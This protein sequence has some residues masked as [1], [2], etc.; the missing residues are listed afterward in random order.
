MLI[1][2]PFSHLRCGVEKQTMKGGCCMPVRGEWTTDP[3]R[4]REKRQDVRGACFL[5][6]FERQNSTAFINELKAADASFCIQT[7][8]RVKRFQLAP[9]QPRGLGFRV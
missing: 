8:P 6:A 1:Y 7:R 4:L 3:A 9:I 2:M 5:V